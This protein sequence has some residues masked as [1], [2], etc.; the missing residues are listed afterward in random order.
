MALAKK[1][2]R[3]LMPSQ[4]CPCLCMAMIFLAGAAVPNGATKIHFGLGAQAGAAHTLCGSQ[5][6]ALEAVGHSQETSG[7]QDWSETVVETPDFTGAYISMA[8]GAKT[9]RIFY[10]DDRVFWV[11]QAGQIRFSIEGQARLSPPR[12][13]WFRCRIACPSSWR[14]WAMSRPCAWKC[15]RRSPDLSDCRDAGPGAGHSLYPR[16]LQGGSRHL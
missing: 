13:F 3:C 2:E 7:R 1:D 10:S 14:R 8:P 5:Q 11:V 12:D 4:N 16:Q 9:K 15:G 6:A